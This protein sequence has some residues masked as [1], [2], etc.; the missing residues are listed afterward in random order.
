MPVSVHEMQATII[1]AIT[2]A[3]S[4][5][6]SSPMPDTRNMNTVVTKSHLGIGAGHSR[7]MFAIVLPIRKVNKKYPAIRAVF[8]T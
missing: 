2:S 7:K 5:L 4:V 6:V 8:F 1:V 3:L